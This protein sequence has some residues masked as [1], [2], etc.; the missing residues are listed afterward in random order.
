M[1]RILASVFICNP[2]V[3]WYEIAKALI[4][5]RRIPSDVA[6]AAA[7]YRASWEQM[8]GGGQ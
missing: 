1:R 3:L 4:R 7:G 2:F 8:V 5:P 6:I